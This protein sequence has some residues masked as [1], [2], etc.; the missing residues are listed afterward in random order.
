MLGTKEVT[1]EVVPLANGRF[2]VRTTGADALEPGVDEFPSRTE[3]EAWI[4]QHSM[5][6]DERTFDTGIIKPGD[7][8]GIA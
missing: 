5:A 1:M 7:G 8:Q 3:A 2:A 4:L 6:D